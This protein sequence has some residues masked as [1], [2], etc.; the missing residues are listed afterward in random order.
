VCA[1][2][3][4]GGGSEPGFTSTEIHSAYL[5]CRRRK[6]GTSNALRFE[7]NLATNLLELE[8][9]LNERSYQPLRSACFVTVRPKPREIF[10]ADFRDRVVHHLLVREIEPY[11]ERVF[12]YDSWAC[13]K[14]KGTHGAV[15]R[16]ERFVRSATRGGRR[17]AW[18]LQIDVANFFMSIDRQRLFEMLDH[19]LRRQYGVPEGLLPLFSR[20]YQRYLRFRQVAEGVV[21]HDPTAN[22]NRRSPREAWQ[23]IPERKSLFGCAPGQ[24]LP[25]GNLTSQFFAN[26]YLNPL[27]Q[28]VKHALKAR[29]YVRYVDDA[30][31]IHED[32]EVLRGWQREIETFLRDRL[33]LSLNPRAMKLKPVSCGIDFLGYVV[34][35]TH[36]LV[37]RRVVGSF[38]ASLEE[39]GNRLVRENAGT[40]EYRFRAGLLERLLATV[41]SYLAHFVKAR[42]RTTLQGLLC[43]Q[44]WLQAFLEFRGARATRRWRPPAGLGSLPAQLRWLRKS[45]PGALVLLQVGRYFEMFGRDAS[46]A[47]EHLGLRSLPPRT[48]QVPRAGVPRYAAEKLARRA[49]GK[50]R[51]VLQVVE[52]GYSLY[53]LAERVPNVLLLPTGSEQ[54][55][56]TPTAT[57][58]S[59]ACGPDRDRRSEG[60]CRGA[61]CCARAFRMP[62]LA[63]VH[64][65]DVGARFIAPVGSP[66]GPAAGPPA[67]G[68]R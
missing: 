47:V 40:V 38:R 4:E 22:F 5:D 53:G 24:G 55:A 2:E 1:E 67:G 10:A 19:G 26:V 58:A 48:A 23:R 17:R 43:S 39:M 59:F 46:W 68:A 13:R 64:A 16:L 32:P 36:R 54:P 31:L 63:V 44:L 12:I 15:D 56:A 27:D 66:A 34:H 57:A 21:F 28:F 30:V 14:G 33:G 25:I 51:A 65:N 61:A 52:S 60:R 49:A 41:N 37:R 42:S 11:W 6:R 45:F 7:M 8:E 50:G 29:H 9:A 3:R 35:P 18:F 20:D 62:P